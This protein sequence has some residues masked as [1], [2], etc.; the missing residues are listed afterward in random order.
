MSLISKVPRA[1]ETKTKLFGYE[2][3][4]LLIIFLYL[5]I[6]NLIF[7]MTKLK[8]PIVWG[9]TLVISATLYFMKRNKPDNYLQHWGEFTR[10]PGI[11]SAGKPDVNYEPY[12]EK[13]GVD[14]D[15]IKIS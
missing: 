8:I 6:S 15:S 3:A 4:D 10:T 13:I 1:L 12:F 2:L 9:G 11:L 5:A 7:G 14:D